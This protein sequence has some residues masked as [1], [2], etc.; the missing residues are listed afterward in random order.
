MLDHQRGR[1]TPHRLAGESWHRLVHPSSTVPA[2][3]L[4]TALEAEM[5]E[6]PGSDE[7]DPSGRNRA[8]SRNARG[9]RRLGSHETRCAVA[10]SLEDELF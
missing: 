5:S 8:N 7:H 6:H 3:D 9:P 1:P 4:E 2:G 10:C